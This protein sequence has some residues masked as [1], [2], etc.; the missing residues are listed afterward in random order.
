MKQ[1]NQIKLDIGYTKKDIADYIAKKYKSS[2]DIKDIT[3]LKE[4]IDARKSVQYVLNIAVNFKKLNSYTK[5][6]P[7]VQIDN[8][9]IVVEECS[10]PFQ[11]VIV[12][13]GPSGMFCA[14]ALARM[15]L[16]PI[17]LEQGKR[18]DERIKDVENFWK[19]GVLNESSNVHYGEGGAGTFSDGKLNTNAH[20]IYCKM[21]IDE[22]IRYGA[23]EEIGYKSKPHIGT[24][25]L[26]DVV[27]N[28]R[29]EI[30]RLGGQVLFNSQFIDFTLQHNKITKIVYANLIDGKHHTIK[31]DRLI[32]AIGHSH[33]DT[34]KL[35]KEKGL[36]INTKPFAMGVRIEHP[37]RLIN[38]SQYGMLDDRLPSADYKLAVHLPTGRSVF[39]FCMCPGGQ[40]VASSSEKDTIV[41]NGMSNFARN[42]P[43]ANSAILVN[44]TPEDYYKGDVLDGFYFQRHYE[45]QCFILGGQ[46]YHAPAQSVSEFLTGK[47]KDLV[48][49]YRPG[50]TLCDISKGLPD[51]VTT[52]IK[53]A[54]PIFS[55][56]IKNFLTDAILIAIE[57]RSSCPVTLTR[58][59]NYHSTAIHGIYPI[60]EGAGYAGGIITSAVDGLKCALNIQKELIK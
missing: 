22:F 39:T 33:L 35:L 13:F 14:L 50:I 45:R 25:K 44:V 17:I 20:N 26:R 54:L 3:I 31:T 18:V 53:E 11:P 30:L 58:L 28:I 21:V 59:E 19:N 24:D 36:N 40:V 51:F 47:A 29:E 6:L 15:G 56:K 60:G 2:V 48:S 23:P 1:I 38:L 49:S 42:T 34:F 37:Q 9:G 10:S 4:S 32:L 16:K 43:S 52:S 57:S 46:N 7:D 12:G 27:K 8:S 55:T 5:N 41:T